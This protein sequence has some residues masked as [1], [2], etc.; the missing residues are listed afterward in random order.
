MKNRENL[1]EPQRK[2]SSALATA[3]LNAAV[4]Q[5][6]ALAGADIS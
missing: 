4:L 3:S 5:M 1:R 6:G 2:V